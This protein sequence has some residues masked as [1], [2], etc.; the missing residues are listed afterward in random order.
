MVHH[1]D[2]GDRCASSNDIPF[3]SYWTHRHS[4]GRA[5]LKEIV[6]LPREQLSLFQHLLNNTYSKVWTRDRKK[7]SPEQ[8]NVPRG[9]TVVRAFRSESSRN[10]REYCIRRAGMLRDVSTSS[11]PTFNAQSADEWERRASAAGAGEP[12]YR[13]CNEWFLFHGTSPQAALSICQSDFRISLAG[14][15]TGTLYGRGT[16]LAE[17]ITKADEYAKEAGGENAG[18]FAVLLVRAL[19]GRVRYTDEVEPQAEDLTRSCIE[20]PYDC[21]LGDRQ[22]SRGTYREFIFFDTENLYAEYVIIYKRQY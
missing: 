7:H 22:K 13:A 3:P 5:D 6:E 1:T 19:G 4:S 15:S 12:L 8:P 9:Y 17:S 16:Y 2:I 14:G 10:W 20:G 21:V 11:V 18:E